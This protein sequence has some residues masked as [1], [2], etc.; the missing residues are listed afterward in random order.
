MGLDPEYVFVRADG[1]WFT[2]NEY[3]KYLNH[4]CKRAGVSI[5]KNHAF[6]KTVNSEWKR[7]GISDADR[8][9]TLGHSVE[10]NI[11]HY[12]YESRECA[13]K[14]RKMLDQKE[15]GTIFEEKGTLNT[16]PFAKRKSPKHLSL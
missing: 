14:M 7:A 16:I 4:L 15:K 5:T 2:K 11:R 12:T 1:E 3:N 10:T 13:D 6:R 9:E 8:A